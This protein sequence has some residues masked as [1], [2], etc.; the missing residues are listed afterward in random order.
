MDV[1]LLEEIRPHQVW[2]LD[3]PIHLL[4]RLRM[5]NQ[6]FHDLQFECAWTS[7]HCAKI[8]LTL[9]VLDKRNL[10]LLSYT[11]YYK[12]ISLKFEARRILLSLSQIG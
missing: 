6:D 10:G 5:M 8:W 4:R 3:V 9:K 1:W 2:L 12:Q 11:L 7:Y